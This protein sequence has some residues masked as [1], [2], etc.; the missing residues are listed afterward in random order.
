VHDVGD[1]AAIAARIASLAAAC[2]EGWRAHSKSAGR[3]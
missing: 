1:A 2:A 3:G